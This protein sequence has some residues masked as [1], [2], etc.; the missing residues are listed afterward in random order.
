MARTRIG[1]TECFLDAMPD[2]QIFDGKPRVFEWEG[3]TDTI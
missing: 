2:L 3:R 1:F